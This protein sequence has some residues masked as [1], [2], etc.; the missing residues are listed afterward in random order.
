MKFIP[1]EKNRMT[2]LSL[3]EKGFPFSSELSDCK[4]QGQAMIP[5]FA[6]PL[7]KSFALRNSL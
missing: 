7:S 3:T 5:Q 6:P 1:N 4:V 2:W